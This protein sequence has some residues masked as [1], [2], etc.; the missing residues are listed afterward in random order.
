M[1]HCSGLKFNSLATQFQPLLE[2]FSVVP[3]DATLVDRMHFSST[4][5][6]IS[7]PL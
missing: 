7:Q 6:P 1:L 4:C 5:A 2:V 3:W